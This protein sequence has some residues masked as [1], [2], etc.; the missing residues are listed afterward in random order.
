MRMISVLISVFL[1]VSASTA[2]YSGGTGDP[3]DPYQIATAVD[4]IALGERPQDYDKHFVLTAD[5][6]LDPNLPGGKV[7]DKAVIGAAE[8]PTASEGSNR[9]TPFTGV[10]DGRGHV[11]WNLTIVGGGYLGLFAELGAE[12]QVRN[13]GLEAVE[14]S[15]T[16]C[17]VGCLAGV[18]DGTIAMSYVCGS[19]RADECVGGLV[20]LHHGR[21]VTSYSRSFVGGTNSVG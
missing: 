12:A 17:F 4:L 10:F 6:D 16:G 2:Q 13:L 20:G 1:A 7:F 9:A 19:V 3:N 14:V 15:G 8:S 18:N 5:I 11:I 21:I